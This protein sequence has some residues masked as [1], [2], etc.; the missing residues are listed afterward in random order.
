MSRPLADAETAARVRACLDRCA[1][2][3]GDPVRELDRLGLL[4]FPRQQQ[5]V[6]Q[7]VLLRAAAALDEAT[8]AQIA[9]PNRVP[10][11][12]LDM[13]NAAALWLRSIAAKTVQPRQ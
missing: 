10:A 1:K 2:N 4:T 5:Y 8:V 3:G 12:A 9:A 7:A 11:T 6:E 13:K